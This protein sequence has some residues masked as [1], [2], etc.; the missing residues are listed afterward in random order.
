MKRV[1]GR[2]RGRGEKTKVPLGM[3]F[4]EIILFASTCT[5]FQQVSVVSYVTR[6]VTACPL[7]V[8]VAFRCARAVAINVRLFVPSVVVGGRKFCNVNPVQYC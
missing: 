6:H 8:N 7:S 1:G 2:M 5:T 3:V 4:V